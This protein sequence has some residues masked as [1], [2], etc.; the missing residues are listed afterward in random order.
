MTVRHMAY[1]EYSIH[2]E[3]ERCLMMMYEA[4]YAF[5]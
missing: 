3:L 4:C 2:R 5:R 1:G